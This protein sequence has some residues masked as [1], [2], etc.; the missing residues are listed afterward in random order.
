MD[1][2]N[3]GL[4]FRYHVCRSCMLKQVGTVLSFVIGLHKISSTQLPKKCE[5]LIMMDN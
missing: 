4:V 2:T 1:F 3:H 5:E